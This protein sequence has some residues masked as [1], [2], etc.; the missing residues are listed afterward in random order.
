M[1]VLYRQ[2]HQVAVCVQGRLGCKVER[3]IRQCATCVL[4][5]ILINHLVMYVQCIFW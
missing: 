4:M 5:N 3:T 2:Q 1:P